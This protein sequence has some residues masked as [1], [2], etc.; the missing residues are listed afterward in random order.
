MRPREAKIPGFVMSN[1][2][3]RHDPL[4]APTLKEQKMGVR[5]GRKGYTRCLACNC[6]VFAPNTLRHKAVCKLARRRS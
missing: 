3:L 2:V 1:T 5:T 4:R 6:E